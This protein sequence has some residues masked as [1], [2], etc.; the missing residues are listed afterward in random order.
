MTNR[1]L[2]VALSTLA[3]AAC[4]HSEASPAQQ[5]APSVQVV[6]VVQQDVPVYR[7][8]IG[9][10]E[11]F[12]T[13]EIKP[14]VIGYVREVVYREGAFVRAGQVLFLIDPGTYRD[15]AAA[16][17]ATLE[18]NSVGLEKVR[19]DVQR[20]RNLMAGGAITQQQFD[21]D[22]AAEGQAAAAVDLARANLRQA[23]RNQGWTKVTS[24]VDGIAGIAEVQVGNLVSTSSTM[25]TVSQVDP[26]KVRFSISEA[27][28]LESAKASHWAE[29]R[30]P[31]GEPP[32]EL[33]LQDGSLH[34]QRGIVVTIDRNFST[35]TGTITVQG[36]F[37]NTGNLLRPGQYA[38]VRAAIRTRRDALLVPQRAVNEIQGSY[39]VGVVGANGKF[40][41]RAVKTAEQVG[42]MLVIEGGVSASDQIVVSDVSRLRP[43]MAVRA[44]PVEAPAR[45]ER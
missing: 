24:L 13:A 4:R 16:A 21:H 2:A 31:I 8:W 17:R 27:E 3:L 1:A 44:V 45:A 32:L 9:T 42:A 37:P 36:V 18:N 29:P 41:L 30:R 33:I 19:L 12:V 35:L 14:Q 15:A 26:I 7:E 6:R 38:R 28:Y 11:G 20:D 34:E 5:P 25:T 39:Q 22:L 40:D 10:L 43:G 23:E